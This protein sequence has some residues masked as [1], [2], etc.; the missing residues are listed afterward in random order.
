MY[1][2]VNDNLMLVNVHACLWPHISNFIHNFDVLLS[3]G[4]R[5]LGIFVSCWNVHYLDKIILQR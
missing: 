5:L 4:I 2:D 3:F 1:K